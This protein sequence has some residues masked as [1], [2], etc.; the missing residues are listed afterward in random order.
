MFTLPELFHETVVAIIAS[1]VMAT[2]VAAWGKMKD[3]WSWPTMIVAALVVISCVL[4]IFGRLWPPTW[5]ERI[6][7][8]NIETKVRQWL[9]AFNI[10][11]GK[12]NDDRAIFNYS[13]TKEGSPPTTI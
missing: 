13:A 10:T 6:T 4:F 11:T 12:V 3:K 7:D 9:D 1:I 2:G 5:K 8:D